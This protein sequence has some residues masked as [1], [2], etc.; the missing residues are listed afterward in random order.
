MIPA[1]LPRQFPDRAALI[2]HVRMISGDEGDASPITATDLNAAL[3]A[4]DPA[5][6]GKT[7]NFLNGKVTR[8]SAYIR[9]GMVSLN[10][11]R[12]L[13]LARVSRK[14]DAEKLVQEL[15][16]REFWRK[17]QAQHPD[18]IWTDVE[19]YKTGFTA[20]DYTDDLPDDIAAAETGVAAID[21]IIT[22]LK[23]DGYLHNHLRMYL[24]SYVVHWRQVKWQAGARF[25]LS[26]LI[27]A[28]LASNNLSWQWIASTYSSK[29]YIFNLENMQKYCGSL[30]T[31]SA[32][33]NAPLDAS[34]EELSARL[35]PHK[36]EF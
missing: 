23:T 18:W 33:H 28:D 10:H 20:A 34:Y 7:R 4:L 2:D 3:N 8:L 22:R 9:H 6:Y 5:G 27:D 11:V 19:A 13:A 15:G 31:T 1:P 29:P 17:V 24:A 16:W 32:Q 12:N 26:H 35:F 25:M 14:A 21:D 36:Q 30:I